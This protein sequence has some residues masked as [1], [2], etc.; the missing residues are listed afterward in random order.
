MATKGSVQPCSVAGSSIFFQK[1]QKH[2]TSMKEHLTNFA[3]VRHGNKHKMQMHTAKIKSYAFSKQ[4]RN[5][6]NNKK[7]E[8]NG[9]L[10][11]PKSRGFKKKIDGYCKHTLTHSLTHIHR[12]ALTHTHTEDFGTKC[13]CFVRC[14]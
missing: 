2:E 3:T 7:P 5:I 11:K 8:E 12:H 10:T 9:L 14:C 6:R 13:H 4:T 1:P